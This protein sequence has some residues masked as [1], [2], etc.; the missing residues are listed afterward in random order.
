M[1]VD[2]FFPRGASSR[3]ES[4]HQKSASTKVWMSSDSSDATPHSLKL[5]SWEKTNASVLGCRIQLA[6]PRNRA[7]PSEKT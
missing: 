3:A 1:S 4:T 5:P 6:Q 2:T 7:M